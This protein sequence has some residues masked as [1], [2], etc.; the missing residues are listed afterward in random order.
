MAEINFFSLE[1][2]LTFLLFFTIYFGLLEKSQALG[3]N[4]RVNFLFALI[5]SSITAISLPQLSISLFQILVP[6]SLIF[7]SLIWLFLYTFL[8]SFLRREQ[9]PSL[10]TLLLSGMLTFLTI[11]F[12]GIKEIFKIAIPKIPIASDIIISFGILFLIFYIIKNVIK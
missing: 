7:I 9:K 4:P 8:I 11:N 10:T 3:K 12:L 1:F 6:S 2:L 5:A